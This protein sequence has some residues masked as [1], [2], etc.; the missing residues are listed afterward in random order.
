M[1]RAFFAVVLLFG[2]SSSK[3]SPVR[4]P[5]T[6]AATTLS[7][8]SCN[9]LGQVDGA[10]TCSL[11]DT[12]KKAFVE[13]AAADPLARRAFLYDRWM[14]L[15]NSADRQIAIRNMKDAMAPGDPE[16]RWG[17]ENEIGFWDDQ[18][19]SAGFGDTLM[20][21]VMFRYAV[22]GTEADYQRFESW[23][24]GQVM[25]FDATGM[26]GYLA[27]WV[28]GKVPAGTQVKNGYAMDYGNDFAIPA[29]ALPKMPAWFTQGLP[30]VASVQPS[31]EGHVSIDAYSGPM[32]S[33][34]IAYAL[35]RD[36]ALKARM[37]RHYGCFLKRLRIFKLINLSKNA[38]LQGDIAHYLQSGFINADPGDP[39]LTKIDQ[40]WGFYL[41]QYNDV[42]AATYPAACPDHLATDAT[43]PA[44][45]I[46]VT[47]PGYDGKLFDLIMRQAEQSDQ[48]NSIDFAFFTSVRSGDALMLQAWALGAYSMTGD[49]EFLRWRDQVVIGKGNAREV[50]K[51]TGSFNFPRPCGS[52]FR[53]PNVYTSMLTWTLLENDPASRDFLDMVWTK[54]WPKTM[55]P[56]RD[57]LFDIV[58]S[59]ATG[60]KNAT[61]AQSL[62]DLAAMGGAPGFLDD[63]RRN[64]ALDLTQNPPPG[65]TIEKASAD[66]LAFCSQPIKVLGITV[67]IDPPNPDTLY[68]N[69]AP[70]IMQRPVDNWNWEKDPFKTAHVAGDAGHQQYFGLDFTEPYWLA[71]YFGFLPDPHLVLAWK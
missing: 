13:A 45:I 20:N 27:R 31:W 16:S 52:Y 50:T 68:A 23:I 9:T 10:R 56:L 26:D 70:P 5:L 57:A 36:P 39:D 1:S 62:A 29:S 44:D 48:A 61:L 21:S 69:P 3:T 65:I 60:Q 8:E 46:D 47:V 49:E 32:N 41:P 40:I 6:P 58:Q 34:P 17:D 37:A 33:W 2:C 55:G 53:T 66:E 14:D 67:P 42:S 59:G 43:S 38:Q 63:P 25:K 22:T 24:R 28:Y 18:G 30:G 4:T 12:S 35:A 54:K 64:Y 19:D 11:Y 71:R 15:Y 51:T 7:V